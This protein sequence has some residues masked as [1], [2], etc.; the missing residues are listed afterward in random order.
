MPFPHATPQLSK[1]DKSKDVATET[2]YCPSPGSTILGYVTASAYKREPTIRVLRNIADEDET[3]MRE[4]QLRFSLKW[5]RTVS[6]RRGTAPGARRRD[7]VRV[8]PILGR[9][10]DRRLVWRVEGKTQRSR[11]KSL[12]KEKR[13]TLNLLELQMCVSECACVM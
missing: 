6:R 2:V 8:V 10:A 9:H 3:T 1:I 4:R 11:T 7:D 5:V 12:R 13:L